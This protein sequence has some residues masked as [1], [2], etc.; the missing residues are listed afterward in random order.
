MDFF[1][2]PKRSSAYVKPGTSAPQ[3]PKR[4]IHGAKVMLCIW[5]DSKGVVYYELLKPSQT[6]T[7]ELYK[8]QLTRLQQALEEKR[9]E[10]LDRHAKIILQHD[11]A[12]PHVAKAV[13]DHINELKWEVLPHPPYSPDLAPSDFHLFRSMQHGLSGQSFKN[14]AEVK[15]WIDSWLASKEP[16]FFFRGI[17]LLP[18]KWSKVVT[19]DGNYFD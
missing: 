8:E 12:R 16:E 18:E 5:W 1:D 2:N 15:N 19:S 4:N 13:K 7:A 17:H 9:P 3:V 14:Y 10:W 6:V 11:N